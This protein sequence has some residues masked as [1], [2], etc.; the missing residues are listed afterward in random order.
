MKKLA[1]VITLFFISSAFAEPA[2]E[3]R[4]HL[5][6]MKCHVEDQDKLESSPQSPP[7]VVA[8]CFDHLMDFDFLFVE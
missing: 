7:L 6:K 3:S 4:F 2:G 8:K 1:F 5:P